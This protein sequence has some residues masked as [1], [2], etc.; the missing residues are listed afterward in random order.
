MEWKTQEAR[1]VLFLQLVPC[2]GECILHPLPAG[3]SFLA[4]V[5]GSSSWLPPGPRA[6]P[7]DPHGILNLCGKG[8]LFPLP[9]WVLCEASA[10]S[11]SAGQT[12]CCP[13][14]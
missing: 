6:S 1:E 7:K 10:F 2:G 9:P 5:S 13:V 11:V 12:A 4:P 8:I 14:A 3:Q